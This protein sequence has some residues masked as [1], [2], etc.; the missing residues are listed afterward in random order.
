MCRSRNCD[1]GRR[2]TCL[3]SSMSILSLQ[4]TPAW[5]MSTIWPYP[6]LS[7]RCVSVFCHDFLALYSIDHQAILNTV[8]STRFCST[9]YDVACYEYGSRCIPCPWIGIDINITGLS[10]WY[11]K[12]VPDVWSRVACR[13]LYLNSTIYFLEIAYPIKVT[14]K[15]HINWVLNVSLSYRL[16]IKPWK[17]MQQQG[18]QFPVSRTLLPCQQWPVFNS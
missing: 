6:T 15:F 7:S 11:R 3:C 9:C 17:R 8:A 5:R 13:L 12:I 2:S 14:V 16:L 4:P 1:L 18:Q 10:M